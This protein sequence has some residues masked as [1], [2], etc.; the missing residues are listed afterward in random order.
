MKLSPRTQIIVA[1]LGAV[2]V[3]AVFF[4][5]FIHSR[6]GALA[7][8]REAVAAEQS[9]TAQLHTELARLESIRASAPE[10]RAALRKLRAAV[11]RNDG[12]PDVILA[13]ED[14]AEKAG[15]KFA[16][17]TP[18]VPAIPPEGG[19]L[20]QV[21][22]VIGAE[23]SYFA[24]QDFVNRLYTLDRALRIDSLTMTSQVEAGATAGIAPATG[25]VTI[26]LDA[27]VRLFFEPPKGAEP[28]PDAAAAE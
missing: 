7:D 24:L 13:V 27:T 2:V 26:R 11:P 10:L 14:A 21:T 23:G 22:A 3:L 18:S 12:V 16:Q 25:P 5:F 6:Q 20:G 28:A 19:E 4:F 1:A 8:A 17:V 9:R 15:I